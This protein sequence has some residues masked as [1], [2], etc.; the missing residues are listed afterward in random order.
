MRLP[1]VALT[2]AALVLTSATAAP[3]APDASGSRPPAPGSDEP[4]VVR[5]TTE[6]PA[7]FDDE[8]GGEADAD[9][10]AIWVDP[11]EAGASL[12]IATAKTGGLRVY[13]LA[14]RELQSIAAPPAPGPDAAPGR[15]NNVDVV[16]GVKLDGRKVDVAVVT[17]RGRDR[18]RFYAIDPKAV[19]AGREPLR[20]VTAADAPLLFSAD[21]AAVDEQATGYGLA[22]YSDDGRHYAVVSRRSTSDL[23]LVQLHS[24]RGRLGYAVEDTLT[25]P[26][27][28]TLPD[29]TSWSPCVEPGEGPQVEGMVVDPAARVLYAAQEDVGLWALRLDVDR[30]EFRTGARDQRLVETVAEFGVPAT[31]DAA[32]EECVVGDE[33]PGFGGRIRADVEGVTLYP[34]GRRDGYLLVSSQ[35]DNRFYAYDR[36]TT[37]PVGSFVV[38]DGPAVDGAEH[39]DGAAAVSTPLPGYPQGLLVVHDGENGP[40]EVGADGEVR[41]NAN[42]K[43]VDWRALGLPGR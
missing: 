2:A 27:T 34:T 25:L 23:G 5:A 18:L 37:E 26:S 36:R 30:E 40:D 31:F 43:Y 33:D 29:A 22:T 42:F 38:G 15:F 20:D 11:R 9:D 16:L 10:P 21:E 17:D 24:S 1:L 13:D 12:V 6:T 32:T 35:G 41:P 4:R 28:F 14:G 3:A 7:L 8:A 39:S 19:A